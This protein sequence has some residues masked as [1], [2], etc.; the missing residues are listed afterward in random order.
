VAARVSPA[1]RKSMRSNRSSG[2]Q[3]EKLVAR[4]LRA[5]NL[6]PPPKLNDWQLPGSPDFS[7]RRPR[8]ALFVDGCFWHSCPRHHPLSA[9]RMPK[10]NTKFWA[11]KFARNRNR[12]RRNDRDLAKLG[13]IVIRVWECTVKGNPARMLDALEEA[14]EAGGPRITRVTPTGRRRKR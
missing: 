9:R 12:D 4:I 7:W 11:T 10:T 8:I 13:W 3:L 2:T 14:S 6:L 1:V 5:E